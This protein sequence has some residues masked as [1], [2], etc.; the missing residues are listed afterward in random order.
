[1][2]ADLSANKV[3]NENINNCCLCN[4]PIIQQN[5]ALTTFTCGH[6]SHTECVF[7]HTYLGDGFL[8]QCDICN[9]PIIS[10]DAI[11]NL[12]EL[13]HGGGGNY[14]D[15]NTLKELNISNNAF[16]DDKIAYKKAFRE[17]RCALRQFNCETKPITAE[18]RK[19]VDPLHSMIKHTQTTYISNTSKLTSYKD[20][21]KK[22]KAL[23]RL[24]RI[25]TQKWNVNLSHYTD[26]IGINFELINNWKE[27]SKNIITNKFRV[28]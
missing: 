2:N 10:E 6:S 16:K 5:I 24:G 25:I 12:R 15:N 17:Y 23:T 1:M 3:I 22:Q 19:V 11:Y 20:F 9:S 13:R 26:I 28:Y 4:H 7:R 18:Y 27:R 21:T 8:M 14:I